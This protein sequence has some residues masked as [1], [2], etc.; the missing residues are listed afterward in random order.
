MSLSARG[1]IYCVLNLYFTCT[2]YKQYKYLLI[3]IITITY[4]LKMEGRIYI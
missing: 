3:L 4:D 1:I 2:S